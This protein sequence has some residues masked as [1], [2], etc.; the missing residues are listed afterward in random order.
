MHHQSTTSK[1]AFSCSW[2]FIS[3]REIKAYVINKYKQSTIQIQIIS[4][5]WLSNNHLLQVFVFI[6]ESSL[7]IG[8]TLCLL[9]FQFVSSCWN[10][11]NGKLRFFQELGLFSPFLNNYILS[12]YSLQLEMIIHW[13]SSIKTF[14]YKKIKK[15]RH[16]S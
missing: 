16:V 5:K 9:F 12:F 13:S 10:Q 6:L 7:L 1:Q 11:I 15:K 4:L 14:L 2:R 3:I 8:Q